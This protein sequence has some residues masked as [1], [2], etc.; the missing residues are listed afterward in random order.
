[1]ALK[2]EFQGVFPILATPFDENENLDLVSFAHLIRFMIDLGVNGVTI[3]GVLGEANRM[4]DRERAIAIET[5]VSV[6]AGRIPVVV[7]ASHRGTKAALDLA[8]MAEDLGANAVMLTPGQEPIPD[9]E[10]IFQY[11]QKVA[12]G[13][14]LPIVVQDHP[15]STGVHMSVSLL[16]RLARELPQVACFKEEAVPTAPKVKALRLGMT[17]RLVPIL[18]GLGALYGLFDLEAGADGFMT[19]FAFPEVLLAM[20]QAAREE[21][22]KKVGELYR[23][24]LPLIVFEQQPGV[25]VRKELLRR[26]G[27][28]ACGRVRHPG[29]GLNPVAA[30]QLDRLLDLYWPGEDLSR[31]LSTE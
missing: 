23:R 13:M 4:T 10:R 5:A 20:V 2:F 17:E 21:D 25:A 1:M 9:E 31:A 11:F 16:L 7:G 26:R 24:F 28:L 6:V 8:K 29:G 14:N 12:E 22:M 30:D 19:G 15:A 27:L 3:L 18:T